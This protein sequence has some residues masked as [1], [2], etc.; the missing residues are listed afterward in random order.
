[1]ITFV[2]Y[3]NEMK[4]EKLDHFQKLM[5]RRAKLWH[6]AIKYEEENTF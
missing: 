3:F 6:S 5:T 2:L 4:K 1:M